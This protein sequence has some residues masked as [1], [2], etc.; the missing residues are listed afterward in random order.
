MLP[1]QAP[2][3]PDPA[4]S[5][6]SAGPRAACIALMLVV[7]VAPFL[8]LGWRITGRLEAPLDDTYTF[9]QYARSLA[10]G[11]GY[12]YSPGSGYTTGCTSMLYPLLLVPGFWLGLDGRGMLGWVLGLGTVLVAASAWMASRIGER[13]AGRAGAIAAPAALIGTGAWVWS[14]FSGLETPL[15]MLLLLVTFDALLEPNDARTPGATRRLWVAIALLG[16]CRPD[17]LPLAA[18]V[19]CTQAWAAARRAR[20]GPA[21]AWL[22]ALL[23]AVA[24][25]AI[26]GW[27]TGSPYPS[28]A[29]A[30]SAALLP[31]QTLAGTLLH[32]LGQ[33][34]MVAPPLLRG[35]YLVPLGALMLVGSGVWL[36]ASVARERRERLAS[37][38]TFYATAVVLALGAGLTALSP[39]NLGRYYH[40][41]C[42]LLAI[43][44][45]LGWIGLVRGARARWPRTAP[46][47]AA[48]LAVAA[49]VYEARAQ[50]HWGRMYAL[51][52]R[53]IGEQ[54]VTMARWIAANEP[55]GA[56]VMAN[57]V[58]AIGYYTRRPIFDLVGLVTRDEVTAYIV[59]PGAVFERLERM[60]PGERPSC[61]AIYPEWLGLDPLLGEWLFAPPEIPD[62][63]V[64]GNGTAAI[65]RP[66]W[67]LLGSGARPVDTNG[68]RIVDEV[69]VADLASEAA[70]GY[71][72]D[73]LPSP[74]IPG[75]R[76]VFHVQR[77]AAGAAIADGGRTV[78]G[79]ETFTIR[80]PDAAT[81]RLCTRMLGAGTLEL[82]VD[83]APAGLLP[84]VARDDS[85]FDERQLAL[86]M[87]A[88][89]P[90]PHTVE[91][92]SRG[93]SPFLTFHH[94]LVDGGA[95][96][97]AQNGDAR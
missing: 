70:H 94:W 71:R 96:P 27:L 32:V 40:N 77:D 88:H 41:A 86:P 54:Q 53:D 47:L 43:A 91:I 56:V 5:R 78:A 87:L 76:A 48:A 23:P 20:P 74:P 81:P 92:V 22:A 52:M 97:T 79:R 34:R 73:L 25:A 36:A 59:G 68:G 72:A 50:W 67:N 33:A 51:S 55:A 3:G 14:A 83:G 31:G 95:A 19:A 10:Q 39:G 37:G 66:D 2:G 89:R 28:T 18:L 58:G 69:D 46:V 29:L 63:V 1:H 80:L 64:L 16:L 44:G 4:R 11:R 24:L 38:W 9:L 65:H 93:N 85:A 57:D 15:L 7:G 17:A 21:L 6:W 45:V 61:L 60:R 12:E 13:A 75:Q 42:A 30:K 35:Y 82:R 49:L 8:Y 26:N 90:G 84:S 62:R